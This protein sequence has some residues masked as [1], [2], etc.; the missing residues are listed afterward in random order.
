[1]K[2]RLVVGL[3]GSFGSGKTTV[4]K[5]LKKLGARKIINADQLAR[6]TFKQNRYLKK[7]KL[8]F[9][10]IDRKQIARKVFSNPTK[11]KALEAMVHPYVRDRIINELRKIKHGVVILEVPLLFEA[12]FDRMCDITIAVL[13][14]RTNIM[15]RLTRA[16][17]SRGEINSRLNAQLSESVKMKKVDFIIDNRKSEK[18]LEEKTGLVWQKLLLQLES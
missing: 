1:M 4:S 7:I 14:G 2:K 6:E 18:M 15:K 5:M 17:F 12:K 16:G 13:A 10:T 9:H 3:T 11:R 8:L